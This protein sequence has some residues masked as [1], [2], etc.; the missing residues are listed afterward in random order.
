M[1]HFFSLDVIQSED[2]FRS[3]GIEG[4]IA[5]D[6]RKVFE[7]GMAGGLQPTLTPD[8]SLL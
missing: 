2:R 7:G 1:S 6:E 4:L 5:R 8:T 3:V